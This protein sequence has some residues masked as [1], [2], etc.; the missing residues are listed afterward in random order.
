[1]YLLIEIIVMFVIVYL[2]AYLAVKP[3]L[4]N[5]KQQQEPSVEEK[6]S[7]LE[8]LRDIDIIDQTE[9]E[10]MKAQY[11][12]DG[13]KREKYEEYLDYLYDLKEN[14]YSSKDY[15]DKIAKLKKHFNVEQQ[16]K[17]KGLLK[18]AKNER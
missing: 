15:M 17:S 3:L 13:K 2:A 10:E 11:L 1:M 8:K 16:N 9:F 5:L 14:G 18:G 7:G 12:N 4:M 6:I